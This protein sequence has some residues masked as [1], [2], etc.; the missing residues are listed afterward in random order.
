MIDKHTKKYLLNWRSMILRKL[1]S[2]DVEFARCLR[3]VSETLMPNLLD[4]LPTD[5]NLSDLTKEDEQCSLLWYGFI[6]QIIRN[7]DTDFAKKFKEVSER[8]SRILVMRNSFPQS[9]L[10]SSILLV[11]TVSVIMSTKFPENSSPTFV[12]PD[13]SVSMG[14]QLTNDT[15]GSLA[16]AEETES[17]SSSESEYRRPVQ[18]CTCNQCSYRAY[19]EEMG[20]GTYLLSREGG[21]IVDIE[22]GGLTPEDSLGANA[23][24][25]LDPCEAPPE[26]NEQPMEAFGYDH[27][28]VS[29]HLTRF[30]ISESELDISRQLIEGNL[31]MDEALQHLTQL[32]SRDELIRLFLSA[33]GA[34]ETGLL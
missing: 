33:R 31:T 14:N 9:S 26:L 17:S 3:E 10:V 25:P 29:E 30:Q 21:L 20:L 15:Q 7:E 24:P 11:T 34:S 16:A 2:R 22:P 5:R 1:D 8:A 19:V 6:S 4:F 18:G 27:R 28:A 32:F 13:D 23:L 12:F